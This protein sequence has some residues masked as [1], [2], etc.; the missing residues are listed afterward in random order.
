MRAGGIDAVEA[1]A[2]QGV[3][4]VLAAYDASATPVAVLCSTDALYAER[5][6]ETVAAPAR[7]RG[8]ARPARRHAARGRDRTTPTT[9]DGHLFAGCDALAVLDAVHRTLEGTA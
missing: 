9:P 5:A 1:G 7:R 8:A 3:D 6:A 2:T 4:D